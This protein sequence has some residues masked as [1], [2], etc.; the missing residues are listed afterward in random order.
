MALQQPTR[1]PSHPLAGRTVKVALKTAPHQLLVDGCEFVIEDWWENVGGGS[2]M[3]AQG[4]PACLGYAIRAGLG[5]LPTD[6][7]VVYGKV[8]PLG[9][10]VH[11]SELGEEVPA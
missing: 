6:D 4:N 9:Y 11:R 8:G 1:R 7:D 3:W 5:G 10:L 2:W